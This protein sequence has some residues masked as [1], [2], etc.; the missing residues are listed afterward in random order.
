MLYNADLRTSAANAGGDVFFDLTDVDDQS[1]RRLG[2]FCL[3]GCFRKPQGIG[4][5]LGK[6]CGAPYLLIVRRLAVGP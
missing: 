6:I 1:V 2:I 4:V 3:S 5:R